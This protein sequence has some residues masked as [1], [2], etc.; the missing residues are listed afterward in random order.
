[1]V[2]RCMT[3][4][5]QIGILL[6]MRCYFFYYY[7]SLQWI[8]SM[9]SK[10]V[11]LGLVNHTAVL[12]FI[13]EI[14]VNTSNEK[15]NIKTLPKKYKTI[16]ECAHKKAY[17]DYQQILPFAR[18][19][20]WNWYRTMMVMC[21]WNEVQSTRRSNEKTIDWNEDQMKKK[22]NEKKSLTEKERRIAI[23]DFEKN[24]LM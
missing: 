6:M 12:N 4:N 19:T 8:R 2:L 17:S 7:Y 22:T 18:R 5:S 16:L 10:M 21:N 9:P 3:I 13:A 14:T 1:M 11:V 23:Q 20:K 15:P 24:C